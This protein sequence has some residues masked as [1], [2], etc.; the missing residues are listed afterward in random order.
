MKVSNLIVVIGLLSFVGCKKEVKTEAN[1]TV[2]DISIVD[3]LSLKLNLSDKW[4]VN[5]ETHEGVTKMN[6]IISDFKKSENTNYKT[7]GDSLSKQTSYI[8]KN[9]TMTGEPHDQ[10]HVVLVPMLD[11]ISMLRETENVSNATE[12]LTNLQALI[13]T[14]FEHFKL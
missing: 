4:L 7:L 12:A 5:T 14:Y 9:C 3:T 6:A 11:E 2:D 13:Q 10:L 1:N 8:I